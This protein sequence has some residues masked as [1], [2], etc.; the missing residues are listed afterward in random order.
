MGIF[1]GITPSKE[2]PTGSF[3]ST[4]TGIPGLLFKRLFNGKLC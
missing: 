1:I 4:S 3:P 2:T